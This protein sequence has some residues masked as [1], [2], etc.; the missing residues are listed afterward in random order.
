MKHGQSFATLLWQED[1][2]MKNSIKLLTMFITMVI[3]V[4]AS[5]ELTKFNLHYRLGDQ[6]LE[7]PLLKPNYEAA[8]VAGAETCFRFFT[9]RQKLSHEQKLDAVDVCA[10]PRNN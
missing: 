3:S 5:A 2:L 6:H 7:V 8:L 10:N 1:I 4:S 9:T